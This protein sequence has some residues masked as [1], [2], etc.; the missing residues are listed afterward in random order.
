M[1]AQPSQI[2]IFQPQAEM[3]VEHLLRGVQYPRIR[4]PVLTNRN[5]EAWFRSMDHWFRASGIFD[6]GQRC[7]TVLA[8]IDTEVLDQLNDQLERMPQIGKYDFAKRVLIAHYADSEQRRL[9]RLLSEMPLGD[10]RP[11]ELYHQM[12]QVAGNVIGEAALKSL[13]AQRLPETA[14]PVIAATNLSAVEFTR[15]ADTIVDAM[16]QQRTVQQVEA[17]PLSEIN[18]LKAAIDELRSQIRNFPRELRSRSRNRDSNQR[19]QTP[20][21]N[22]TNSNASTSA[23]ADPDL[24]WYHQKYGRDA[25]N[26]RSPCRNRTRAGSSSTTPASNSTA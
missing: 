9:N 3:N 15:M 19:Q 23:A 17:A 24:C 7:E 13:W 4:M 12:K 6:D 25:R 26:C 1:P 2:P 10:K 22:A 5:I 8:T 11:S 20:A 21:G 14:R 18:A 16:A